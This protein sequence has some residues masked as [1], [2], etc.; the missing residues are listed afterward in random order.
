M[1]GHANTYPISFLVLQ[2]NDYDAFVAELA[3]CLRPGGVMVLVDGEPPVLAENK[4]PMQPAFI[5]GEYPETKGWFARILYG[6]QAFSGSF[7]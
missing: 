2:I 5:G 4:L 6:K 1:P 7:R 3:R